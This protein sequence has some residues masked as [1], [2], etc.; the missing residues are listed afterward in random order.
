MSI[1][2]SL[3]GLLLS[4]AAMA[5]SDATIEKIV[6]EG[7]TKVTTKALTKSVQPYIGTPLN[8]IQAANIA[9]DVESFYHKN[10]YTLAFATVK[11]LDEA[12]ARVT[13][14]IGKY[15]N[16]DAQA[17]AQM[18]QRELVP[19]T[20]SQ[21]YFEGNKKIST[22]RLMKIAQ[23]SI[24]KEPTAENLDVLAKNVTDYYRKN[25]Y[26]LAYSE[27]AN[28]EEGKITIKIK[29]YKNFKDLYAHEGKK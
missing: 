18:Q 3:F 22:K 6:F 4:S 23:S 1:K 19:N 27:V 28:N 7:N 15:K 17:I 13:I 20:I 29:K 14:K 11:E 12:K 9:H 21:V 10:K 2:L 16:F 25:A 24:G 5:A 8:Q 26:A